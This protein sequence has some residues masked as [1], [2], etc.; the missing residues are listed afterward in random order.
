[1]HMRLNGESLEEVGHKSKVKYL[2]SQVAADGDCE[3]DVVH[4]MK[5]WVIECGEH[6]KVS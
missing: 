4:R 2:G 1:M 3:R 6:R 5:I